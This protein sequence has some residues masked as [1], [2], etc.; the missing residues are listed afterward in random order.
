MGRDLPKI[1]LL[2]DKADHASSDLRGMVPMA[3]LEKARLAYV[4]VHSIHEVISGD[5]KAVDP[6]NPDSHIRRFVRD[7]GLCDIIVIPQ[8]TSIAWGNFIP[9]WQ[10]EGKVVV[11]DTDDD[12]RYVSPLSPCYATRGTQE[13]WATMMMSD[14]EK[15]RVPLWSDGAPPA[16]VQ[17]FAPVSATKAPSVKFSIAANKQFQKLFLG[18]LASADAVTCPTERYAETIRKEINPSVFTLPN[19]LD[20]EVWKPGRFP[21]EARPGFRIAWHG[22]DSHRMDVMPA[23]E[24]LGKFL[25]THPDAT[26]VLIGANLSEWLSCVPPNQLEY[27]DWGSY[28]SHPWRLMALG[29]DL[30]L[31]PVVDHRFNDAKSPLK[32]TEFGACGVPSI[33]SGNP[34]YSD[35]VRDGEDGLLV[36]NEPSA[37]LEALSRVYAD[38]ALR[39]RLGDAARARVEAEF[40]I[41]KM[42]VRW[43]EV[44]SDLIERR[45]VR[46]VAVEVA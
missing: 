13:V 45:N 31:C 27:W 35:A 33:C 20:L 40:D 38:D 37:W 7:V 44:Y 8:T 21:K 17:P 22:G 6:G 5:P 1:I 19:C 12:I 46:R 41:H 10:K 11:M 15:K 36:R 4:G 16:N 26:F 28:D 32:W 34:P 14:G 29:L 9:L 43:Y 3:V 2:T 24:G 25:E 18:A 39:R 23:A 30:G 42:A